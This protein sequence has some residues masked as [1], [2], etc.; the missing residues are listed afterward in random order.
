MKK[1]YVLTGKYVNNPSANGVCTA[2]IVRELNSRGENVKVI[3]YADDVDNV[4]CERENISTVKT[5]LYLTNRFSESNLF[6]KIKNL[7]SILHKLIH[8]N[9]Y[10]LR[11]N[12]LVNRYVKAVLDDINQESI[13]NIIVVAVVNP[14]ESAIAAT[15][16][17]KILGRDCK[18]V[19]YYLDTLSNEKGNNGIIFQNVRAKYGLKWELFLFERFDRIIL[20]E[21]QTTHY[22]KKVYSKFFKKM[23]SANFP[24]MIIPESKTQSKINNTKVLLYAGT[25]D[26]KLR[27]PTYLLKILCEVSKSVNIKVK[28]YGNTNCEN[29]F[30]E[31]SKLSSGKINYYGTVNHSIIKDQFNNSDILLSIGNENSQ[32]APS[33]IYEY[34]AT[35]KPILHIYSD[36][37]DMCILPLTIYKNSLLIK[38]EDNISQ[39]ELDKIKK[40]IFESQRIETLEVVRVFE[41][42]TPQYTSN[43]IQKIWSSTDNGE[44]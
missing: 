25:T 12:R 28:I 26:R 35:G 11:S 20:M 13:E 31:Y 36:I 6:S 39:F 16:L 15:N 7:N 30:A 27:N 40:F 42:A 4:I 21:S 38:R 37:D 10:P 2:N 24:L 8:L 33:K 41:K 1:I 14:L 18:I 32:M 34:M 43:I 9:K 3:C 44:D 5:P 29:I 19:L 22:G 17:K 23:E